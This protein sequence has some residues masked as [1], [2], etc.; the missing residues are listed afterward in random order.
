LMCPGMLH[1]V[2]FSLD[3]PVLKLPP[4]ATELNIP[5]CDHLPGF[6]TIPEHFLVSLP[7]VPSFSIFH[8]PPQ[9]GL[10]AFMLTHPLFH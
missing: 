1:R 2:S 5:S 3:Y 10:Q 7:A 6:I 4:I 9:V 8:H